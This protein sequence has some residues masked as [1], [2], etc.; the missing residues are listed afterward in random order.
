MDK[1]SER[2]KKVY[3]Q[4][5]QFTYEENFLI[6]HVVRL[7]MVELKERLMNFNFDKETVNRYEEEIKLLENIQQKLR[8]ISA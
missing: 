1:F 6:D 4:T 5:F 7:T 3:P 2:M 8:S